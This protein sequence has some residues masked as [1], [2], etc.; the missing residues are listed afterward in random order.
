MRAEFEQLVACH[1]RLPAFVH[2]ASRA[3]NCVSS[4]ANSDPFLGTA[5][6]NA[7]GTV[8]RAM[9]LLRAERID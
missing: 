5:I 3:V 9:P 1:H 4:M 8:R 6:Q 2:D 7:S